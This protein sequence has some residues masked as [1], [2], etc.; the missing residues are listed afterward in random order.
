MLNFTVDPNKCT[1]CGLCVSD[2]PALI[3][4][5]EGTYVPHIE[6]DQEPMCYQCQHCLAICPP[7]ALSILGRS[8][9]DSLPL[10]AGS[11]P[12]LDQVDRF[13]RGRRSIRQYRDENV[14]S[15]LLKR[16]IS[17][18]ANVPTGVN[19][20]ELTFTVI[21]DRV[22]M[23]G[24]RTRIYKA[25]AGAAGTGRVPEYL[26]N[27]ASAYLDQK[28]D[29]V[30]RGAPHALIVSAPPDA[31]C[32]S[33]DVTLALAYFEFLA[34]SA[35]LGTVWWGM[36]KSILEAMPELKPL[37]NLQPDHVYYAMLFGIP[38]I[39]FSRTVQRDDAAVIRRVGGHLAHLC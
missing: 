39:R 22:V 21:D 33:Q 2:C 14:D 11:L 38:A 1:R 34:Q 18:L 24:L 37:F 5:Q 10:A 25:L 32:P 26:T 3:I 30:F 9:A 35:G 17:T 12:S 16:L 31:P 19:R 29:R 8:P 4:K 36:L 28:G 20:R 6:P 15:A 27:A 7:A 13:V 23:E